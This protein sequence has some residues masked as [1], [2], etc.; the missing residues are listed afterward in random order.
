[1]Q[2]TSLDVETL[3]FYVTL[4][5]WDSAS[6]QC[7]PS[8]L[9]LS[10][11]LKAQTGFFFVSFSFCT[12]VVFLLLL[13]L[14]PSLVS[15]S[16]LHPSFISILLASPFS[17]LVCASFPAGC[18]VATVGY[19]VGVS[20]DCQST[21]LPLLL[22]LRPTPPLPPPPSGSCAEHIHPGNEVGSR[23]PDPDPC[24]VTHILLFKAQLSK[25]FQF[26][27]VSVSP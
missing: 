11:N 25:I 22:L 21:P 19:G 27:S 24:P 6:F 26:S 1:M 16:C 10:L 15:S 20:T 13:L 5:L 9:T 8:K 4:I 18:A 2:K 3:D 7:I 14:F 12:R 23:Q 17:L